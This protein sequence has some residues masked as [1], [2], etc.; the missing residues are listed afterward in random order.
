MKITKTSSS[1]M[2]NLTF[3]TIRE[4]DDEWI[5]VTYPIGFNIEVK[6]NFIHVRQMKTKEKKEELKNG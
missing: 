4:I 5:V 2:Q 1:P 6:G 3:T